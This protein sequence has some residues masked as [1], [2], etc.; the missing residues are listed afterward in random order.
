MVKQ[1]YD[2]YEDAIGIDRAEKCQV[3]LIL[4]F[5]TMIPPGRGKEYREMLLEVHQGPI[6]LRCSQGNNVLHYSDEDGNATLCVVDHKTA[7]SHRPQIIDVPRDKT[8]L[9]VLRDYLFKHRQQLIKATKAPK[10]TRHLF[11]VRKIQ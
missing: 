4:M 2:D 1:L 9:D 8:C 11:L 10:N 5:Y 3:L 7:N 6:D